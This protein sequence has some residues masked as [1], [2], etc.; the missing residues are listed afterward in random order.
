[1]PFADA[2][3]VC[4]RKYVDFSGRASRPEYWWFVLFV[5]GASTALA[6]VEGVVFGFDAGP[7]DLSKS[8][9][10]SLF[11]LATFLPS[12]SSAVRRMHDMGRSGWFILLPL[13]PLVAAGMT[14]IALLVH[15]TSSNGPTALGATLLW[16]TVLLGIVVLG[17]GILSIWWLTRPSEPG[18]NRWGPPPVPQG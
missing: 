10:S 17:T 8:P 9:F 18:P 15:A 13:V 5:V 2:V 11:A 1:M 4:L 14:G 7:T 3:R 12:T 16:L 6:I